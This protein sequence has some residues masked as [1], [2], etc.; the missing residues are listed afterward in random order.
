MGH[1]KFL[2]A[3][4]YSSIKEGTEI[5]ESD[6]SIQANETFYQFKYH[7]EDEN[8]H[9]TYDVHPG[10]YSILKTSA[11][12]SLKKTEFTND[13]IL[14]E[15]VNTKNIE[16]IVDCFFT[17]LH[18]YAEFGIEV[19]KRGVLL[20]GPAGSGKTTALN[21]SIQKY[22]KDGKTL[23]VVWHTSKYEAHEVQ[24]FVKSF[25]YNN[26]DKIILICED[27]GGMENDGVRM[28]SDSSLL[29]LLDNQEKTFAL[30]VMIIATTNYPE[31]FAENLMNRSGRF[32]DKIKVGYPEA[33]ARRSLLKFFSKDTAD[34][35]SLNL[36]AS[37][38]CKEF[39]PSHIRESY[40]RSRLRSKSL[41]DTISDMVKEIETYKK[42][43]SNQ[44]NLGIY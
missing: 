1:F 21:K 44:K 36:M 37:D 28:R 38:K 3:T 19:P 9:M 8:R 2:K 12:Y 18:L 23:V 26:I 39:P 33:E 43:F 5:P 42:G 40:I 20:Y 14:D 16:D 7:E 24:D 32:D 11:G 34:E 17:N 6:L 22:A 30:P 31:N 27:L 29:S 15:F 4:D 13:S 25:K 35:Q 10:I 41:F